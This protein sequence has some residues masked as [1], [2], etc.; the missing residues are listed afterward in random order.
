M[1][2]VSADAADV[3]I[4]QVYAGGG[5]S[6][7][8][9]KSDFVELHNR[10]TSA[11]NITGWTVQ[12]ANGTTNF[13]SGTFVGG[14]LQPGQYY[15]VQQG[16]PASGLNDLPPPN[17]SSSTLLSASGGKIALV[18]GIATLT[19]ACPSGPE[20]I[21][22]VGYGQANCSEGLPAATMGNT[23]ALLRGSSGCTDTDHNSTDFTLGTPT[24]HNN[25]SPFS[26][27]AGG[28][29]TFLFSIYTNSFFATFSADPARSNVAMFSTNLI[30]WEVLNGAVSNAGTFFVL[31][32]TNATPR[33]F[34]RIWSQ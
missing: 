22:F 12:Y 10:G 14:T 13:W 32:D 24:P 21:D 4:S 15:L 26:S 11:V 29:P 16:T 2:V 28:E 25:F 19:D 27:C 8:T 23:T 30:S 5:S 6:S 3:I 9:Y 33:R 17:A 1:P 18:N 20:I 31:R 7:S 34:Y